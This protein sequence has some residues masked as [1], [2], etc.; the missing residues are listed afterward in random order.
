MSFS[1]I[2]SYSCYVTLQLLVYECLSYVTN[3]SSIV[4]LIV[5]GTIDI[6]AT[7]S[8]EQAPSCVRY[9]VMTPSIFVVV[10]IN[11]NT[12]SPIK[13]NTYSRNLNWS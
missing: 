11:T 2:F 1:H 10:T 7:L 13:I 8:I 9:L 4:Y 3:G 6:D 12:I 5:S